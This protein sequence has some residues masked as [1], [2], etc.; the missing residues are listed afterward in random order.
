VLDMMLRGLMAATFAGLLVTMPVTSLADDDDRR[1]N[2]QHWRGDWDDRWDDRR[3]RLE[4]RWQRD[5]RRDWHRNGW[6][7]HDGRRGFWYVPPRGWRGGW[8]YVPPRR[9]LGYRKGY[10]DYWD[11]RGSAFISGAITGS[12]LTGSLL[13]DRGDQRH[14]DHRVLGSY[15]DSL[16]GRC[17]RIERLPGGGER[18]VE[19]PAS[20]C[21]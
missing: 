3:D 18:R 12:L 13:H 15:G 17:Y 9:H 2:A 14:R 1:G 5:R 10:R 6:R 4:K 8:Y 16:V 11:P 20:A 7:R 21:R 19:L